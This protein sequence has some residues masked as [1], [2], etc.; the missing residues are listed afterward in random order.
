MI[1]YYCC[2]QENNNC[3]MKE[4]CKRFLNAKDNPNMTLFRYACTEENNYHLFMPRD[5][6]VIHYEDDELT[7]DLNNNIDKENS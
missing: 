3:C 7:E 2:T 5:G 1:T 6:F 4:D